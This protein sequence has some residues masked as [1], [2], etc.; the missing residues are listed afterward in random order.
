MSI[1]SSAQICASGMLSFFW[2]PPLVKMSGWMIARVLQTE[3]SSSTA[4]IAAST[5][6]SDLTSFTRSLA[7]IKAWPFFMAACLSLLT[8]TMSLSPKSFD[9]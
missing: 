8:T 3:L 4:S 7:G 9:F 2:S 5:Q 1:P 6:A